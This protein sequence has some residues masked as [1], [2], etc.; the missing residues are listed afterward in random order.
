METRLEK[1]EA[2]LTQGIYQSHQIRKGSGLVAMDEPEKLPLM[3]ARLQVFGAS[4]HSNG[5]DAGFNGKKPHNSGSYQ[6]LIVEQ[7][8]GRIR[9]REVI[10]QAGT[11]LA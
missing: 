11:R 9:D 1:A 7:K 4:I 10:Y 3:N 5:G 2:R 8:S 6:L